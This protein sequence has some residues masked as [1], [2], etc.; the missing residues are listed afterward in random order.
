M[1]KRKA[2]VRKVRNDFYVITNGQ[3][4]EKV[5]FELLRRKHSI[6]SVHVKFDNADPLRLVEYAGSFLADANQV[7]CVFDIDNSYADGRLIPALELADRTGVK[8]AYSNKCFEVWML[9]HFEPY[10][11][12]TSV[13]SYISDLT[14]HLAKVGYT[15]GYDK[16]D[17]ALIRQYFVPRYKDAIDNAK[18]VYQQYVK[19]FVKENTSAQ[20]H[21]IWDWDASTTVFQLIQA[22]GLK[23]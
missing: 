19:Q 14:A 5:Y 3:Q 16:T 21:P 6:Y 15:Q 11:K 17:Q 23:D 1:P 20:R 10:R 7:W 13:Q 22:M 4:T 2:D 9:A 8:I 12:T 18:M